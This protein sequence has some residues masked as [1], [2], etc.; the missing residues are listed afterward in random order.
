MTVK[1][2]LTLKKATR[3]HTP[4]SSGPQGATPRADIQALR[5]LAVLFVVL[6]HLWPAHLT[7]GYIGVD[8]FFVISG[9][10]ITSHLLKELTTTSRIGFARFYARRARRLLPAALTVAVLTLGAS[11]L[12]LPPGSWQRIAREFFASG[13][14]AQ[15]WNLFFTATD[16]FAQDTGKTAFQHYWS[17][18]VEEQFYLFW[19][20]LLLFFFS[21]AGKGHTLRTQRTLLALPL[22]L[23]GLA[24]LAYAIYL[25]YLG[26]AGAYFH[27]FTRVWEFLAGALVALWVQ[28]ASTK[29]DAAPRRPRASGPLQTLGFLLMLGAG[30]FLTE[31]SGVPGL[32]ALLPVAGAVLVLASGPENPTGWL[33]PLIRS[34]PVQFLGD[35]SYSLYLWHWPLIVLLPYVLGSHLTPWQQALILPLSLALA[36]LTKKV[37]E[38]PVRGPRFAGIRPSLVLGA[39]LASVL[40]LGLTSLA[41]NRSASTLL[42]EQRQALEEARHSSQGGSCFGARALDNREECAGQNT[43]LTSPGS[44]EETPWGGVPE[45]CQTIDRRTAAN[46]AGRAHVVCD[47]S[48]GQEEAQQVWVVGDSHSQQW[49]HALLPYA[50]EKGWE[51]T[52]FTHG[53]CPTWQVPYL[54]TREGLDALSPVGEQNRMVCQDWAQEVQA[55]VLEAQPDLV[56]VGNFSSTQLIGEASLEAQQEHYRQALEAGVEAWMAAGTRVL[57]LRDTP[58]A[59]AKLGPECVAVEGV[60]CVLDREQAL[61]PDPQADAARE[62]GLPVLD[63]TSSFCFE[64]SCPGVIGG[65][66][67]YYDANH[68]SR[69]YVQSLDEALAREL[70]A[71]QSSMGR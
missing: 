69:S 5:A 63:L 44:E 50:Q 57:F 10:L 32:A 41:V 40:V 26:S 59:G 60:A 11:L 39:A 62:L 33:S 71:L 61:L 70:D 8:I 37:I 2:P 68:L 31:S 28:P 45:H 7:G 14:Y 43:L 54:G 6:N 51:L 18:S 3:V 15:N 36:A 35:V 38:D 67:V 17:L 55:R 42:A 25:V 46:G 65:V 30:F 29:V 22:V 4:P 66:A 27:T 52:F 12:L 49:R 64:G 9:F 1:D 34:R 58:L 47:Y 21:L 53:G 56:L 20:L 16:Y 23:L 24:S 48:T 19:P 13:A